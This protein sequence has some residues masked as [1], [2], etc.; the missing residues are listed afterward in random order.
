[1]EYPPPKFLI[2][3]SWMQGNITGDEMVRMLELRA[4]KEQEAQDG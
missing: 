3:L 4:K 1:M 2:V